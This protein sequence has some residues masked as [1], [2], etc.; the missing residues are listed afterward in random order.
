MKIAL[1]TSWG[2]PCGIAEFSKQLEAELSKQGQQVIILGNKF[3]VGDP[4]V[5]VLSGAFHVQPWGEQESREHCIATNNVLR[6]LETLAIDIL[7]I[8]FQQTFFTLQ[9]MESFISRVSIPTVVTFHDNFAV[10]T[11]PPIYKKAI[12]HRV[13]MLDYVA[14]VVFMELPYE[15]HTPTLF[16]FGLGRNRLPDIQQACDKMGVKLDYHDSGEAWLTKEELK[17]RIKASDGVV[18]WYDDIHLHDY[19]TKRTAV[20]GSAAA[21]TALSLHRPVLANDGAWFYDLEDDM[22][23]YF[24]SQE[25]LEARIS[26]L[27]HLARIREN[28]YAQYASKNIDI[29]EEVSYEA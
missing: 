8:Q 7:H 15:Q 29:Y 11:W 13:E 26:G 2:M 4:S 23:I 20:A 27:F 25:E 18:L 19:R 3:A 24:S 1:M 10:P 9:E 5:K 6:E 12:V 21:R 14:E 22:V 28:S 16:A 17:A